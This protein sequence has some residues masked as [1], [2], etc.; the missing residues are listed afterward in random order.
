MPW[1]SPLYSKSGKD[2]GIGD[3]KNFE[4]VVIAY[5]TDADKAAALVPKGLKLVDI[6]ALPGQAPVNIVWAKY[7][8]VNTIGPYL[9]FIVSIPVVV[10]GLPYMYVAAIYVDSD[11]A[12]AAGREI[13]GYSKKIATIEQKNYGNLFLG[14]ISRN[15]HTKKTAA[16]DF[17]MLATASLRKGGAWSRCPYQRRTLSRCPS[18]MV[19]SCR[20]RRQTVSRKSWRF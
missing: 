19:I 14:S 18:P 13:G 20:C 6:P 11:S 7:T 2:I 12:M 16:P 8:D 15:D 1:W 9:K 5:A 17:S 3:Y 4:M 10:E